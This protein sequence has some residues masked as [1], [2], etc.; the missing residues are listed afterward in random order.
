MTDGAHAHGPCH[1]HQTWQP[2]S[3]CPRTRRGAPGRQ[4]AMA[5]V[6]LSPRQESCRPASS[7]PG[8]LPTRSRAG[9]HC[10]CRPG[11]PS[12]LQ[13]EGVI[14]H[15]LGREAAHNRHCLATDAL[16]H[17][18]AQ[19]AH[20]VGLVE[21][22]RL[23]LPVVEA[24]LDLG[25]RL[26]RVHLDRASA[27]RD[28]RCGGG[29]ATQGVALARELGVGRRRRLLV[30]LTALVLQRHV[31]VVLFALL[32]LSRASACRHLVHELL[33]Q[34]VR[35]GAE[36]AVV[37]DEAVAVHRDDDVAVRQRTGAAGGC[38]LH[39]PPPLLIVGVLN[40]ETALVTARVARGRLLVLL[41][42]LLQ[43]VQRGKVCHGCG[44]A[45]AG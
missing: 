17:E 3:A 27:G 10:D 21:L 11:E 32:Q 24:D 39:R 20:R 33:V 22:L 12:I 38:L 8:C 19:V 40:G 18:L 30:V 15:G 13:R 41:L 7:S 28:R 25:L 16:L 31:H 6:P 34:R 45:E 5:S 26:G 4:E 9:L 23:F 44:G 2:R 37:H 35:D 36:G 42:L 1:A 14:R 43:G 29:G